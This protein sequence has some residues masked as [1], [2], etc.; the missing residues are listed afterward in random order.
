VHQIRAWMR[1]VNYRDRRKLSADL[2]PIY[3]APNADA[4][5]EELERFDETWGAQ[6]PTITAAWQDN[7]E[8]IIQRHRP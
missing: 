2:R 8:H 6:Y 3:T 1:D 4:A 5:L 7:W